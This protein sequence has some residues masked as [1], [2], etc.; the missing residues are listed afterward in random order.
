MIGK[1]ISGYTITR[2]IG[3]GGMA[4]VY[5]ATDM[6]GQNAAIKVLR[7][8]YKSNF[9]LINRFKAEIR[10]M[11]QLQGHPNIVQLKSTTNCSEPVIIMEYLEGED[12][13]S[14]IKRTKQPIEESLL[15]EW[16]SSILSALQYA[17]QKNIV[18]RDLKP[19][20]IFLTK[21]REIKILDFGISKI[22]QEDEVG[23]IDKTLMKALTKTHDS[24]G[25][26]Q[27]MSPEQTF[28]SKMVT[29]LTDI[30]SFGKT[31]RYLA[32]GGG[33]PMFKLSAK[34]NSVIK[35]CTEENPNDRYRSVDEI[36]LALKDN[37]A[38]PIKE[39]SVPVKEEVENKEVKN[40]KKI[41]KKPILVYTEACYKQQGSPANLVIPEKYTSIG[42]DAFFLC[43]RLKSVKISSSV[44]SIGDNA[45]YECSNLQEV[46]I[47]NS[48]TSI[49][50]FAFFGCKDLTS[51]TLP[52][53]IR[54]I[55]H[56]TFLGCSKLTSITIPSTVKS[57]GSDAF[58]GC[59][60]LTTINIPSFVTYIGES[61][62][63]DCKRL[64]SVKIYNPQTKIGRDAFK[65]TKVAHL[66]NNEGCYLTTAVCNYQGK[67]DDCYELTL[68][69]KFRDS[70]LKEQ[71]Y[72]ADDIKLY[73]ETAPQIV[74]KIDAGED[75]VGVYDYINSVITQCVALVEIEKYLETYD[76]HSKMVKYLT[77]KYNV[78]K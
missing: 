14:Y 43:K 25:T 44:T 65:N 11:V 78:Y 61:A 27:F 52:N 71:S 74:E 9:N 47:P 28:N 1:T 6:N 77:L 7:D 67:S 15:I 42:N 4:E 57:I 54:G 72:G 56:R 62:F 41:A 45:F 53:T 2:K 29:H 68:L 63:R 49:G 70:W 32:T 22:I 40:E 75:K 38:Q 34:L 33:D 21:F 46:I 37:R 59:C 5:L 16:A 50:S 31:L 51:V 3:E 18:H 55:E 19:S 69:R 58:L 17:H 73:Y 20:N 26:P 12:L 39:K 13:Y 8:V 64:S 24:L 66:S 23:D 30:Y 48:V 76:L 36:I 60:S 35:K 10:S